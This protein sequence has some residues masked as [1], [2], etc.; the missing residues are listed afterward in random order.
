MEGI[1]SGPTALLVSNDERTLRT[2]RSQTLKRDITTDG[3]GSV[4][5]GKAESNNVELDAKCCT[6]TIAFSFGSVTEC[7]SGCTI[8][9]K[10]EE[11]KLFQI[12]LDKDQKAREPVGQ[13]KSLSAILLI[14]SDFASSI[15]VEH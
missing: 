15:T 3:V 11:E 14:K 13:L 10:R 12:A 5:T 2:F 7:P 1:P 9:G 6:K 8:G 4:G